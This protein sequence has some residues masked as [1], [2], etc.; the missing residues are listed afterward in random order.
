MELHTQDLALRTVTDED[1]DEVSRMWNFEKGSISSQE[2]Q[3]AIDYMQ[4]NHMKNRTGYIY[5]LCFAVYEK[6]KKNIIGWCGLDGKCSPGKV[7]IFYLIDKSYRNKGFATQCAEKLLEYAFEIV[8]ID[9][10]YGGCFK[11]NIS[12][13][14]VQVK[15]Q[16]ILYKVDKESGDPHF[17]IDKE[18]YHKIKGLQRKEAENQ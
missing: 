2:A 9:S 1:I 6:G 4:S 18:I 11:D 8:K 12:S 10:V 13:Y 7:V 16:M 17:Y 5:H 15:T 14:K 3:K